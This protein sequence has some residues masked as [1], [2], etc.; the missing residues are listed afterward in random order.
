MLVFSLSD[1]TKDTKKIFDAAL[2][3]EVIINNYDGNRFK[4]V[5]MENIKEGKSPLEDIPGI[6][7][8]ITTQ[9]IVEILRECRA[10]AGA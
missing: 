10:G 7:L 4:I 9:E 6:N 5:P 3:N 2:N 8:N 1:L